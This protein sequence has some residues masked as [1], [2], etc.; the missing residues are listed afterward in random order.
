MVSMEL[1]DPSD[2][3]QG[4]DAYAIQKLNDLIFVVRRDATP[5]RIAAAVTRLGAHITREAI[6]A[7]R[8]RRPAAAQ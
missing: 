8:P 1:V 7:T 4:L 2:M 6:D 3:P 5:E